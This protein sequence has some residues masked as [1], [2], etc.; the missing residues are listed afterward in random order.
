MHE[1]RVVVLSFNVRSAVDVLYRLGLHANH[2]NVHVFTQPRDMQGFR[3]LHG[4]HV[5]K[6]PPYPEAPE[7]TK[8]K[9]LEMIEEFERIQTISDPTNY[10]WDLRT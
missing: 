10:V 5:I 9:W 8:T 2:Q 1:P 3:L 7:R 4:D 6:I